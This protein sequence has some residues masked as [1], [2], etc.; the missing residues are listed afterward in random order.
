MA[1]DPTTTALAAVAY[2]AGHAVGD[3]WAQTDHQAAHKARPG[4]PGR[5]V[6]AAHVGALTAAHTVALAL[7]LA[8]TA[9]SVHPVSAA[10]GLTITAVTHYWADRRWTLTALA[11]RITRTHEFRV[12]GGGMAHLVDRARRAGHRRTPRG[13]CPGG[14]HGRPGA[15]RL[16][17]H[18]GTGQPPATPLTTDQSPGVPLGARALPCPPASYPRVELRRPA[19]RWRLSTM[20]HAGD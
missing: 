13:R 9:T 15:G 3:Y 17:R 12:A 11:D 5:R 14:H 16:P 2:L 6:C 20:M 10:L 8:A 18:S 19:P 1:A 4:W 7:V